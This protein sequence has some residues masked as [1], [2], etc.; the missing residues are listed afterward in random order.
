MNKADIVRFLEC[1]ERHSCLWNP[2]E[3]DYRNNDVRLTALKSIIQEMG[4]DITVGEL[5]TKIKNI[6]T[7]YSR[8]AGKVVE[9]RKSA[10]GKSDV[11]KP[12]LIW[13][14]SADCFLKSVLKNKNSSDNMVS[15]LTNN[16]FYHKQIFRN[17]NN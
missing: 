14:S 9:S 10:S 17:I 5:K 2:K 4:I 7:T 12:Q 1:Y 6:R 15:D 3:Q 13:F 16:V 8:E 11:Y